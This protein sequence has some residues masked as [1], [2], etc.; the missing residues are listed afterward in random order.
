MLWQFLLKI[1][2]PV[3]VPPSIHLYLVPCGPLGPEGP[4]MP[5]SLFDFLSYLDYL[6]GSILFVQFVS[7]LSFMHIIIQSTRISSYVRSTTANLHV[8]CRF[9]ST[10]EIKIAECVVGV[11]GICFACTC[12]CECLVC[13]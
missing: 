10:P 5:S 11:T 9:I 2:N 8:G 6:H 1:F 3:L 12:T 7:H 4:T 13:C